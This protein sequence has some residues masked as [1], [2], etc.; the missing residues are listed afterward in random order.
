MKRIFN[1]LT[2]LL[3]V[4]MISAQGTAKYVFYFIETEWVSTK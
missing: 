1:L 2:F 3:L 4:G